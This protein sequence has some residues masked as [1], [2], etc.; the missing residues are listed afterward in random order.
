MQRSACHPHSLAVLAGQASIIY[1]GHTMLT[2][3]AFFTIDHLSVLEAKM[4]ACLAL[5]EGLLA[6]SG[7]LRL[8]E[9]RLLA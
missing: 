9:G 6:T 8:A 3:S 4:A 5:V 7:R 2:G 1:V